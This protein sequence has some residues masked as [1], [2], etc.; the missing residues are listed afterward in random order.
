LYSFCGGNTTSAY[1][2]ESKRAMKKVA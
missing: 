1:D 2:T